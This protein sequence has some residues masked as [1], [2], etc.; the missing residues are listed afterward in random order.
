MRRLCSDFL[1]ATISYDVLTIVIMLW[2]HIPARRL[3][4]VILP[5]LRFVGLPP[6]SCSFSIISSFLLSC[7]HIGAFSVSLLLFL[8]LFLFFFLS[9]SVLFVL[10]SSLKKRGTQGIMTK[11]TISAMTITFISP[12]L[13]VFFPPFVRTFINSF[14]QLR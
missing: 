7:F 8:L 2:S 14:A 5:S 10:P 6:R 13:F 4:V 1:V 11:K 3:A 9:L 12:L